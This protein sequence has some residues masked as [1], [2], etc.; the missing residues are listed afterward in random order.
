MKSWH[1]KITTH[2]SIWHVT[3]CIYI[4]RNDDFPIRI[5]SSYVLHDAKYSLWAIF[6]LH[7]YLN[8]QSDRLSL[9]LTESIDV[10]SQSR[11]YLFKISQRNFFCFSLLTSSCL[12]W[13]W[14][15]TLHYLT[16]PKSLWSHFF[17]LF[18]KDKV[19]EVVSHFMNVHT[20]YT[21]HFLCTQYI[22]S[23]NVL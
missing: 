8:K 2:I 5:L 11:F 13:W 14:W 18:V 21:L 3:S 7:F 23:M 19:R 15:L 20:V 22:H 4:L 10:S 1:H 9:S 12:R 17:P 6:S 16:K